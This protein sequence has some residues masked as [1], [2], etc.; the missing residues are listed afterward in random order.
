MG[1]GGS[2]SIVYGDCRDMLKLQIQL[3]ARNYE[4]PDYQRN[5]V[6][7][8]AIEIR[9]EYQKKIDEEYKKLNKNIQNNKASPKPDWLLSYHIST[10]NHSFSKHITS[11]IPH[12]Q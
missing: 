3:T 8:K 12:P 11:S 2:Q 7:A 4:M 10:K 9:E 1:V 6:Y 5:L